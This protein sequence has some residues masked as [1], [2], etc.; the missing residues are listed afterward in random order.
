MKIT[1]TRSYIDVETDGKVVRFSGELGINGFYA[2][3]NS[4]HWLPP[5]D[6]Q[7]ITNKECDQIV[8]KVKEKSVGKNFQ[9]FF[10]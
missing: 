2:T 1:G 8:E 4:A 10:D 6:Q 9:V 7:P 3:K 5:H